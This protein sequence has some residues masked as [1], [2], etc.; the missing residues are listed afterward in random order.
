MLQLHLCFFQKSMATY[1]ENEFGEKHKTQKTQETTTITNMS[2]KALRL[3]KRILPEFEFI[4]RDEVIM[5]LLDF[6]DC[7][8]LKDF[9]RDMIIFN[10]QCYD[11]ERWDKWLEVQKEHNQTKRRSGYGDLHRDKL[12]D[13]VRP[14]GVS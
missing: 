11:F 4:L 2:D 13:G 14:H 9:L 12:L 1:V 10:K 3:D 6:V 5:N 8:L 7:P